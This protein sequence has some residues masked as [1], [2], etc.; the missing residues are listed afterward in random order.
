MTSLVFIAD[1]STQSTSTSISGASTY[2]P[3]YALTTNLNSLSQSSILSINNL[4]ATSTSLLNKTNFTNLLVSGASTIN[5]SLNVSGI[6]TLSNKTIINGICNIH[7]GNPFAVLN[8][9]MKIGSLTIGDMSFD[10]GGS[11]DWTSNTAGLMLECLNNTEI[12]VHDAGNRVASL[13]YY[14]GAPNK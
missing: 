6:T 11:S 12:A 10:Y 8:N 2:I 9:K 1:D 3:V 5:S 7:G 13:M 14:E 4:N